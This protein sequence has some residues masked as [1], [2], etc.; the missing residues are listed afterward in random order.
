MGETQNQSS[1]TRAAPQPAAWQKTK[2]LAVVLVLGVCIL[3]FVTVHSAKTPLVIVSSGPNIRV[4]SVVRTFGTIH[5]H[6]LGSTRDIALDWVSRVLH[7]L[8]WIGPVHSRS[9]RTITFTPQKSTVIWVRL[10]HPGF[11]LVPSGRVVNTQPV[12]FVARLTNTN[13]VAAQLTDANGRY[14]DYR[15]KSVV[16]GWI[17]PGELESHLGSLIR[18]EFTNGNEAVTLRVR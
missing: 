15:Q 12:R 17:V 18:I 3:L 9:S 8:Q 11:G 13:G 16:A 7:D 2:I 4:S 1:L 5:W 6:S 10:V 14:Q